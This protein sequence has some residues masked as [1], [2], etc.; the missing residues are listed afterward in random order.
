M[1]AKNSRFS[2]ALA[3][4]CGFSAGPVYAEATCSLSVS[5]R[6]VAVGQA[7][8][9]G[10]SVFELLPGVLPPPNYP[11]YQ[12]YFYGSNP[13]GSSIGP[14]PAPYSLPVGGGTFSGYYNPGGIGG[15]YYR[16]AAVYSGSRF[17]CWTNGVYTYL[18]DDNDFR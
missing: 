14:E 6:F 3:L 4:L 15:S 9:F 12:V 11:F 5:H 10:V 16:V 1:K 2:I 18:A 13:D 7:Y 8:Q 17:V